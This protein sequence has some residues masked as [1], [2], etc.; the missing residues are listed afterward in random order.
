MTRRTEDSS[1]PLPQPDAKAQR[2]RPVY[3]YPLVA[4]YSG[5][6]SVDDWTSF[7]AVPGSVAEPARYAW[8]GTAFY[9]ADS[10]KQYA[11]KDG[12]LTVAGSR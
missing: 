10:L 5:K 6:G 12:K 2:T 4:K 9:Q 3:P 8:E 1:A 7:E 11:V